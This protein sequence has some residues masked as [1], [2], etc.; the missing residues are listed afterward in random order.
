M[1]LLKLMR[2]FLLATITAI[3]VIGGLNINSQ[4]S[5]IPE[6]T[7][8]YVIS[9]VGFRSTRVFS[10]E[11]SVQ[12]YLNQAN[13]PLKNYSDGGKTASYW[14]FNA[15]RGNTSEK[16]GYKPNLNP[17]LILAMLEKE[18]SL[19]S[20]S[21]YDTATDPDFRIRAAMGYACPDNAKC[22]LEYKGF[23]NQ[24]NW[25][26]FQFEYNF[27]NSESKSSKVAPYI[28]GNKIKTSDGYEFTISNSATAAVY[29]YTPHAYW[30]NYNLWKIMTAKG[31]GISNQAFAYSELENANPRSKNDKFKIQLPAPVVITP[32]VEIVKPPKKTELTECEKVMLG[33]YFIGQLSGSVRRLQQCLRDAGLYKF[34]GGITGY[35]GSYTSDR[36]AD[37][38]NNPNTCAV[39]KVYDYKIGMTGTKVR[40][41]QKCMQDAGFFRFPGGPTGYFGNVSNEAFNKWKNS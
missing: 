24:V 13:S 20:L 30:G 15:A 36:L 12:S 22:D 31:W 23:A 40:A 11:A 16:Y 32:V 5:S 21:D 10:T 3:I 27:I 26:S 19:L 37:Y 4:A 34:S 35:F 6:F 2:S 17:G 1:I 39:Y 41:A 7:P 14:I 38:L 8:D 33:D 9:D 25:A 28:K 29:R 18:Q